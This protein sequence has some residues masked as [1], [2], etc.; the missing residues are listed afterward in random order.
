MCTKI[1]LAQYSYH[2][3]LGCNVYKTFKCDKTKYPIVMYKVSKNEN[4]G[5]LI[6]NGTH[7]IHFII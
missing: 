7:W 3:H 5:L 2:K 4:Y 1:I 6:K